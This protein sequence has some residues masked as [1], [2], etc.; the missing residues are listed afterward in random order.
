MEPAPPTVEN[1]T[2]EVESCILIL[3][4]SNGALAKRETIPAEAPATAST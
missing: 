2:A 1:V 3:S 4:T